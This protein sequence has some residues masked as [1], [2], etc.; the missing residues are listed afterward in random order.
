MA[1]LSVTL[2][3][4]PFTSVC[5]AT[6]TLHPPSYKWQFNGIHW[7]LFSYSVKMSQI[8]WCVCVCCT[9]CLRK[10]LSAIQRSTVSGW[11]STDTIS[12]M[13]ASLARTSTASAPWQ[14]THFLYSV[15]Q[16]W[17]KCGII[18]YYIASSV[19]ESYF[20]SHHS[21]LSNRIHTVFRLQ[22]LP[23]ERIRQFDY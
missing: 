18:C 21:Y 14:H 1:G 6:G 5:T 2:T 4:E 11:W 16:I 10:A 3:W 7:F 17:M 23:V 12:R 19:Y 20:P 9:R 22:D 8:M 13:S 15:T